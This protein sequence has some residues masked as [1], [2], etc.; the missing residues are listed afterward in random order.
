MAQNFYPGVINY[1]Y[2]DRKYYKGGKDT[3]KTPGVK[4]AFT[5]DSGIVKPSFL[6]PDFKLSASTNSDSNQWQLK[7]TKTLFFYRDNNNYHFHSNKYY[8][9]FIGGDTTIPV[10]YDCYNSDTLVLGFYKKPGDKTVVQKLVTYTL[11]G[12]WYFL[13]GKDSSWFI[14]R[15]YNNGDPW[16]ILTFICKRKKGKW[17][18]VVVNEDTKETLWIQKDKHLSF[19]KLNDY[20]KHEPMVIEKYGTIYSSPDTT[21]KVIDYPH[22]K[23]L[24]VM[25]V[26]GNWMNVSNECDGPCCPS[27]EDNIPH[28]SG[29]IKF[30]E[31]D[32]WLITLV[33]Y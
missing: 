16:E 3:L 33:P 24:D 13:L 2:Y 12:K 29:W 25:G 9:A 4:V 6:K 23:C 26:N 14:N 28:I 8:K 5:K 21:S 22:Q 11:N 27:G 10:V 18:E 17:M 30:K 7:N 31:K 19:E 32:K 15:S 1:N 20:V